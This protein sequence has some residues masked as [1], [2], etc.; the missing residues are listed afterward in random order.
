MDLLRTTIKSLFYEVDPEE[1]LETVRNSKPQGCKEKLVEPLIERLKASCTNYAPEAIDSL[2]DYILSEWMDIH[3]NKINC[4]TLYGYAMGVLN[5][6]T[7]N[8]LIQSS[9]VPV[10]R[11]DK[12]LRWKDI[13]LY[14]GEDLL[15][16]S[17]YARRGR[18][19]DYE[20]VSPIRHDN[21][22]F[23]AFWD[24]ESFCD[25]HSHINGCFDSA[26]LSW[27]Y[28]MNHPENKSW[29]YI[30]ASW[31]RLH[32]CYS[33]RDGQ[34]VND[35]E[36]ELN[37]KVQ[38]SAEELKNTLPSLTKNI[39]A[40][41][42]NIEEPLK[43]NSGQLWDYAIKKSSC[44]LQSL[45]AGERSLLYKLLKKVYSGER[46]YRGLHGFI[47]L[48]LILKIN[49][50]KQFVQTKQL[51]GLDNYKNYYHKIDDLKKD[52]L[53]PDFLYRYGVQSSIRQGTADV[54]EVRMSCDMGK[55]ITGEKE[56]A[57]HVLNIIK[58]VVPQ[59]ST[60]RFSSIRE[61]LYSN[62]LNF[63][64]TTKM[65]N[66]IAL[67]DENV[68]ASFTVPICGL[69]TASTDLHIYPSVIAP[70]IRYA[71][72]RG[73]TNITYHI[74][75]EFRDILDGLR[76]VYEY[77]TFVESPKK[78]RLGHATALGISPELYYRRISHNVICSR[79]VL[80]DNLVWFIMY[81]KSIDNPLD[82]KLKTLFLNEINK[83]FPLVYGESM[84]FDIEHYWLSMHLRGD[85]DIMNADLQ[86]KDGDYDLYR[87]CQNELAIKARKSKEAVVLNDIYENP[88]SKAFDTVLYRMPSSV[89]PFI[90]HVQISLLERVKNLNCM[91]ESCPTSNLM[92]GPFERYNELPTRK[93][94]EMDN[95]NVSVNTDTKGIFATSLYEEYSLMAV[96]MLKDGLDMESTIMPLMKKLASNGKEQLFEPIMVS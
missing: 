43:D 23:N 50:R 36:K 84:T 76:M 80:I 74:A 38:L 13:S 67:N 31:L 2:R 57:R 56:N 7:E 1:A 10:V 28:N 69:D 37:E 83:H 89:F 47:Y 4:N 5:Y 39:N 58:P 55:A 30:L 61:T 32:L 27:I 22:E 45:Y 78:M 85:L 48:Y 46:A 19:A 82:E 91:I 77:L 64:N 79:L 87:L 75:E 14:V 11:F 90:S 33:V 68:N 59:S 63:I 15:I 54:V 66:D 44:T 49:H 92:I 6:F 73:T 34:Q 3:Q 52:W 40:E 24:N 94:A 26:D 71:I 18:L 96:S 41:W 65:V 70:F 51:L 16:A 12:L 20:W 86:D 8:I 17:C 62:I 81:C 93:F 9:T 88:S 42:D 25:V 35:T 29:E 53:K 72:S 95:L 60:N 21:A